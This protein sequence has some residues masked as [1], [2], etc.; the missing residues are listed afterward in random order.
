MTLHSATHAAAHR[1]R[2][3]WTV[4]RVEAVCVLGKAPPFERWCRRE[5]PQ[6]NMQSGR[7][8]LLN[9]FWAQMA[10]LAIVTVIVIALAAQYI[11]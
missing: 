6:M 10:L 4:E 7:G 2:L 1:Q 8:G 3:A 11:W 9:N 5:V